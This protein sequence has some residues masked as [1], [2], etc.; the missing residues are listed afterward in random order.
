MDI[1]WKGVLIMSGKIKNQIGNTITS[2]E[3][4][5]WNTAVMVAVSTEYSEFEFFYR[6]LQ[7]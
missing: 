6:R 3:T 1:F 2:C 7:L 4:S 5:G